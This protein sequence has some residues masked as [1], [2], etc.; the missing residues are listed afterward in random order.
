MLG[1]AVGRPI[2]GLGGCWTTSDTTRVQGAVRTC[3]VKKKK[4]AKPDHGMLFQVPM[5]VCGWKTQASVLAT[6]F[7]PKNSVSR[8]PDVKKSTCPT[9]CTP[10]S[11]AAVRG[12]RAVHHGARSGHLAVQQNALNT[13]PNT[14]VNMFHAFPCLGQRWV[15]L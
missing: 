15:G 11:T 1:T 13:I 14:R 4:S 9:V 12:A 2:G 6:K 5:H 3:T 8:P 10:D 7:R